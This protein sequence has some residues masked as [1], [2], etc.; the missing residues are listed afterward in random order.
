MIQQEVPDLM[1]LLYRKD[2]RWS[3]N[4]IF[5]ETPPTRKG[6]QRCDIICDIIPPLGG[7]SEFFA[8]KVPPMGMGTR[9]NPPRINPGHFGLIQINP[10][11]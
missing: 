3:V 10:P 5:Y 4:I 9:I 8:G 2:D 11:D 6:T 7:F 1:I